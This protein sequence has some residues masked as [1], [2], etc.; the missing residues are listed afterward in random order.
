MSSSV[1]ISSRRS[2]TLSD[3]VIFSPLVYKWGLSQ[4]KTFGTFK[5]DSSESF[6]DYSEFR[7]K[8]DISRAWE[9]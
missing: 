4:I 5:I 2:I 9:L 1:M 7:Y 3:W 6:G 8:W